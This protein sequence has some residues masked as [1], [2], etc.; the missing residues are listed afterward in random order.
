MPTANRS[1][2]YTGP[3]P[4][5]LASKLVK[6]GLSADLI[7]IV[8]VHV[9]GVAEIFVPKKNAAMTLGPDIFIKKAYYNPGT[10]DF[11]LLIAEELAHVMQYVD[12]APSVIPSR[13]AKLRAIVGIFAFVPKYAIEWVTK[14][15]AN[16]SYE[17]EAKA[18]AARYANEIRKL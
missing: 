18:A 13:F 5:D 3:L 17:L 4:A 10:A 11:D 9:G 16:V 2:T 12:E 1:K 15:Y 6:A 7:K 8:T 14:G